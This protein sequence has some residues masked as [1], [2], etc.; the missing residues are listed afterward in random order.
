MVDILW[1]GSW[2]LR[3]QEPH[4]TRL[5]SDPCV[6]LVFEDGDML[7]EARLVGVWTR[8]WER[9]LAERGRVYGVKLRAGAVRAFITRPASEVTNRII[10]LAQLA[11]SAG[12]LH[13]RMPN[14]VDDDAA[15]TDICAW[16]RSI[17]ADADPSTR[18]IAVA[19]LVTDDPTIRDVAELAARSRLSQRALQRIF[20]EHVGMTPKALIRRRRLQ[21]AA[22]R[23]DSGEHLNLARLAA[24]LGYADHAHLTRDFTAAVGYPPRLQ[25]TLP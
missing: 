17:R 2:D 18:A 16:L 4:T 24:E 11:P 19:Q 3:G 8:I 7:D 6:N 10:P 22:V 14:W 23:L 12:A 13:R 9:T 1:S 21:E 5:L 20:R 15:F 25:R